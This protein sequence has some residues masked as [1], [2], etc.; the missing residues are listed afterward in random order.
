MPIKRTKAELDAACLLAAAKQVVWKLSHNFNVAQ[1]GNVSGY[2]GPA[3]IDRKDATVKML[4]DAI[5]AMEGR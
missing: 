1:V 3:L 4:V 2:T 5:N